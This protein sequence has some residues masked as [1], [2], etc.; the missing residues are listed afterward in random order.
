MG[1]FFD[2]LLALALL[3]EKLGVEIVK[4]DGKVSTIHFPPNVVSKLPSEDLKIL[5]TYAVRNDNDGSY[6]VDF[7]EKQ[8]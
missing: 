1:D 5:K 6:N 2:A 7:S 4:K 3:H 8:H